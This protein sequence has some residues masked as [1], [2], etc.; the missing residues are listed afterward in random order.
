VPRCFRI[1]RC[2]SFTQSFFVALFLA[3]FIG[4]RQPAWAQTCI[5]AISA[6]TTGNGEGHMVD[7]SASGLPG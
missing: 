7:R 4:A 5:S 6:T 1:F 3:I 2:N